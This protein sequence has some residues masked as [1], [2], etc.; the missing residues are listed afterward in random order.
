MAQPGPQPPTAGGSPRSLAWDGRR[1]FYS[2][3]A[4]LGMISITISGVEYQVI[5]GLDDGLFNVVALA[6][7]DDHSIFFVDDRAEGDTY[8]QLGVVGWFEF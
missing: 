3:E 5:R 6:P 4:T 2:T 1:I 8:S 7:R